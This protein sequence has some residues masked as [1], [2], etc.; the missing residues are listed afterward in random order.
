MQQNAVL[1]GLGRIGAGFNNLK[2]VS[3]THLDA[4]IKNKILPIVLVDKKDKDFYKISK[5]FKLKKNIFFKPKDLKKKI[6][7][8]ILIFS[9]PPVHRYKLIKKVC[10]KINSKFYI[11]EKPLCNKYHEAQSIVKF[12]KK[13]KKKAYVNYQR[14][15]DKKTSAFLKKIKKKKI[16]FIN[17]TYSKGFLNNASH[18]LFEIIKICG[19]IN[20]KS[21]KITNSI[22]HPYKNFSFFVKIGGVPVYFISN[23]FDK[24]KIEYQ[25]LS[26]YCD[27]SI[28][29]LRSG[30]TV[31]RITTKKKNE[32]YPDYSFLN[33]KSKNFHIGPINSLN[34]LYDDVK[35]ILLKKKKFD[36]RNLNISL[37][38]IK[39]NNI[40][41]NY[42]K[43]KKI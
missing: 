30:G 35:K 43:N 2:D 32:I 37:E 8:D 15:W 17:V 11:I 6:K 33:T 13:N 27:Q 5:R 3:R 18:Y 34:N 12:F 26:F 23:K 14:N 41:E 1:I 20:Y 36:Y 25:E 24:R 16:N 19:K 22:N 4:L 28:Y 42:A 10:N 39:L 38:I 7:T 31:K 40:L 29:E 21:L 9:T